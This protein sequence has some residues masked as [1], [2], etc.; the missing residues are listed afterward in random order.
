LG[1]LAHGF[2]GKD[3]E[4]PLE[5][6]YH[7]YFTNDSSIINLAKELGME[8]ELI[9]KRPVTATLLPEPLEIHQLDSP[10]S[11]MQFRRLSLPDRIRTGMMLGF[12]KGNPFWRPLESLTA[13]RFIKTVG[14]EAGWKVIWEPLL[15]GKFNQYAETVAA[16]WFWARIKKRT[17]NLGYFRGGFQNFVETLAQAVRDNRGIIHTGTA[18]SSI[19]DLKKNGFA[20]I[21][22]TVPTP[23]AV[24]L[25]NPVLPKNNQLTTDNYP[26]LTIPHL[27]AQT[28]ILETDKPILKDV[29]WLNINDRAFPFLAAVAHTNFMNP[30]HYNNHH[31]TY[32]GNYLP[33]NHP[34]LSME[35]EKIRKTFMPFIKKIAD[36]Y[37]TRFTILDSHLFSAP[38]AQ[39]VH[40]TG[41]SRRA[42]KLE[43]GIDGILLANMDSIY[44][45]DRGTNYAVE[46]GQ[47]AAHYIS[48]G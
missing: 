13:E 25:L 47:K 48:R 5:F 20:N 6:A 16:S 23:I 1:G 22:L 45:W 29:Y 19:A 43:T 33:N 18:V 17:T 10:Q 31:L 39:P 9:I 36:I 44:P 8:R 11:L 2:S 3:W 32:F 42:P 35:K 38:F 40:E 4:W 15:Y 27:H 46:L 28:F 37:G 30:S 41:Y 21:L 26:P 14:G 34:Y 7:H 24:K 12:C